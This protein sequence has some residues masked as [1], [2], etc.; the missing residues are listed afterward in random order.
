GSVAAG[1][2]AVPQ[3]RH[4][5]LSIEHP[6]GETTV[7]AAVDATGAVTSAAILRTARKL[8]D[9]VVFGD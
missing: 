1:L 2:A 4:K 9:G 6:S 8:F 3:G 5:A 7:I